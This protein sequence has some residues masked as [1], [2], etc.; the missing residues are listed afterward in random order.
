M[1]KTKTAFVKENNKEIKSGAEKYEERRKKKE[2]EAAKASGQTV[3]EKTQE[4]PSESV[5]PVEATPIVTETET[6]TTEETSKKQPKVRGKQYKAAKVKIDR[7][8]L[9]AVPQAVT[10]VKEATFSKFTGTMEL[11]L[12]VKKE[13]LSANLTLPHATGKQKKIEIASDKTIEQLKAGK[14][15]FDVLLATAEMMPK[16]VPFARLLGPKGLMPNPKAGTLIK[17]EKDAVKFSADSMTVKTEKK[18]PVIHTTFGKVDQKDEDL[19]EN[20]NAVLD[21]VGRKAILKAY[22]KSTMSPSVKL[23]L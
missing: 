13:G 19:V 14:V 7:N 21:A 4:T 10:L 5:S 20:V 15:E 8:K 23:S 9:Y 2:E 18:Q 11:H 1:G 12:L 16:L 17:S 6:Q 22:M 3:A